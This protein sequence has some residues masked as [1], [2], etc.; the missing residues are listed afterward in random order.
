M[1]YYAYSLRQARF[2]MVNS[3][4]T[5][6]H[7][8]SILQYS[9]KLL[10][11]IHL[12]PPLVLLE[13]LSRRRSECPKE[14]QIVY[15][16]CDTR[17]MAVLPLEGRERVILS[18]AQFRSVSPPSL[19]VASV[20]Y[21][22]AIYTAIIQAGEGPPSPAPRVSRP[23]QEVPRIPRPQPRRRAARPCRW[24]PERRRRDAR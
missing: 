22:Y 2:I 8:D 23:A 1:Y 7:V 4:W 20:S 24:Q 15:P 21:I 9:D 11:T 6:G 5:K 19:S 10:D 3:S 14:A 13:L 12:L 16:S 17:Q 18:I